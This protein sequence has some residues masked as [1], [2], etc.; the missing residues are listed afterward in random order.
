MRLNGF[1]ACRVAILACSFIA[2][3]LAVTADG[4]CC[5]LQS[6]TVVN[7]CFLAENFKMSKALSEPQA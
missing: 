6:K 5:S 7:E 4:E 2:N 1:V 3:I